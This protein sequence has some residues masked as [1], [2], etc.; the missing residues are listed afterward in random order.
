MPEEFLRRIVL[1]GGA[2][3]LPGIGP[4]M[5]RTIGTPVRSGVPI[6]NGS[7]PAEIKGAAYAT[8]L[9]I[10][11]WATTEYVPAPTTME[12]SRGKRTKNGRRGLLASLLGRARRLGALGLL[13]TSKGRNGRS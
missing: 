7:V 4:L 6:G 3:N 8:A 12:S 13:T 9:G 5:Q 2:S 11:L 10:L 1:T